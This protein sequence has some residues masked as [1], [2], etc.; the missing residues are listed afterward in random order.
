MVS[1]RPDA[2]LRRAAGREFDIFTVPVEGGVERRFTNANGLDDGPNDT[3][4]GQWIQARRT[5]IS[6]GRTCSFRTRME[7]RVLALARAH[8]G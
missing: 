1:R 3:Q 4:D 6:A 8:H 5:L 2:R 7:A